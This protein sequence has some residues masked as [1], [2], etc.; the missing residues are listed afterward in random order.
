MS[1]NLSSVN[2]QPLWQTKQ[3]ALVLNRT[4]P[5]LAGSE[6]AFSSPASQRSKAPGARLQCPLEGGDRQRDRIDVDGRARQRRLEFRGIGGIGSDPFLD[7]LDLDGCVGLPHRHGAGGDRVLGLCFQARI[8]AIPTERALAGVSQSDQRLRLARCPPA[9]IV[10]AA[11]VG[12]PP[13]ERGEM[14]AGAGRLPRSRNLRIEEEIAAEI[15]QRLIFNGKRRWAPVLG[16]HPCDVV[17]RRER[18]RQ[19]RQQD[20]T[21]RQRAYRENDPC[22]NFHRKP[23]G[24]VMALDDCELYRLTE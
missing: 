17:L 13:A 1:W 10:D 3:V 16:L 23:P 5:R 9:G 20:S 7:H 8:A 22:Q 18:R 4:K 6:S 21:H 24:L 14:T 11:V 15:G 19:S 2:R 12:D